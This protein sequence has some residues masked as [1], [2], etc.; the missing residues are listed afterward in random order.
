MTDQAVSADAYLGEDENPAGLLSN[1]GNSPYVVFPAMILILIMPLAILFH[2]TWIVLPAVLG[3]FSMI[4][5]IIRMTL[6]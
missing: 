5:I 1:W 4:A 6:G 3:A 2:P